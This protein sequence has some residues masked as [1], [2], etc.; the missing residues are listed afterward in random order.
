MI[1][2]V[3]VFIFVFSSIQSRAFAFDKVTL[4]SAES[5]C[6]LRSFDGAF[7][8]CAERKTDLPLSVVSKPSEAI[9]SKI[10]FESKLTLSFSC[11]PKTPSLIINEQIFEPGGS[12]VSDVRTYTTKRT[13]MMDSISITAKPGSL[14]DVVLPGCAIVAEN[15]VS[16]PVIEPIDATITEAGSDFDLAD[17]AL[18]SI[19]IAASNPA[20][21]A[22][23]SLARKTLESS[24]E[25]IQKQ[26]AALESLL[27]STSDDSL[28]QDIE[29]KVANLRITRDELS[30]VIKDVSS[31]ESE[32][33][34]AV[35]FEAA[36]TSLTARKDASIA[37]L[38]EIK[39]FLEA[40][41]ARLIGVEEALRARI[42]AILERPE[43]K[44]VVAQ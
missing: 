42:R 10:S 26:I 32:P 1:K 13:P 8:R 27:I 33:S 5:D 3:S 2:Y 25:A 21:K 35:D 4:F 9:S 15:E 41:D 28:K 23:I 36:K 19:D 43:F 39:S 24:L 20:S 6:K 22:A 18:S 16:L 30:S 31:C 37:T 34:C 11:R 38:N 14:S 29:V 17:I 12:S 7:N 44:K 40:E